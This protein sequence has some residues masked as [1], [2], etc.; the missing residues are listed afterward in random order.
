MVCPLVSESTIS[1]IGKDDTMTGMHSKSKLAKFKLE[2]ESG[3][4]GCI[5]FFLVKWNAAG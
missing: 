4:D 2:L 5:P 1:C 3:R